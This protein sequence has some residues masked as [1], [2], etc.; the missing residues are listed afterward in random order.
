MLST[1]T[2][3]IENMGDT[4]IKESTIT[5]VSNQVSEVQQRVKLTYGAAV[6]NMEIL[7]KSNTNFLSQY[8]WLVFVVIYAGIYLAQ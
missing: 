3:M 1:L 7:K 2:P 5:T 6:E 4:Y 8:Y